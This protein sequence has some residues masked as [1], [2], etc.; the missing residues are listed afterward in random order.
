MRKV[1]TQTN[2]QPPAIPVEQERHH[3]QQGANAG[4]HQH[5]PDQP[6]QRHEAAAETGRRT[7]AIREAAIRRARSWRRISRAV[8]LV[9]LGARILARHIDQRDAPDRDEETD[10][11]TGPRT[12]QRTDRRAPSSGAIMIMNSSEHAPGSSMIAADHQHGDLPA[13]IARLHR[14]R[15]IGIAH[16]DASAFMAA[17]ILSIAPLR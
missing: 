17:R 3:E 15:R 2:P 12:L 6:Q 1:I 5:D 10:E 8:R 14:L 7:A 16:A 11:P 13:G 4:K 9:R